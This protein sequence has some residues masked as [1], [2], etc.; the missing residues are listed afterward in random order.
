[1]RGLLAADSGEIAFESNQ[2]GNWEIFLLDLRTGA[3]RNLTKHPADDL[4]PA[5][6]PDGSKLVFSSDRNGDNQP[7]LYVMEADGSKVQRVSTSSNGYRNAGWSPDGGALVVSLGFGQMY[8]MNSDGSDERWLAYGFSP[9]FSPDGRWVLYSA[10]TRT[11]PNSD[12][13]LYDTAQ[14]QI[15]NLT[16][17]PANDWGAVWSPD[18]TRIAFVSSRAGRSRIYTMN[19][20]GKDVRSITTQGANDLSPGWSPD[21]WQIV[22]TSGENGNTQ[23]YVIDADGSNPHPITGIKGDNHAPAWRPQ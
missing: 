6:S 10:D 20:D 13:F 1:M 11:N 22:Y 4:S 3:A 16:A 17:N 8:V 21:G 15:T 12:V 19:L 23:L 2:T 9:S 14:R 5:W 7:E 18:G